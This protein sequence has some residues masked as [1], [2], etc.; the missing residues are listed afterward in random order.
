[1]TQLDILLAK[2]NRIFDYSHLKGS[3][4]SINA[5]PLSSKRA[6][7]PYSFTKLH[8]CN[9]K[10]LQRMEDTLGEILTGNKFYSTEYLAKVNEDTFCNI[11]CF[12]NFTERDVNFYKKLLCS[13]CNINQTKF[14]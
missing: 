7:I 6:I 5:G 3:R 11:L 4:L 9:S 14:N 8:I 13:F 10:R 2:S 1:M 12:N